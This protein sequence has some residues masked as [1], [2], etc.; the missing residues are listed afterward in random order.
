MRAPAA[1][2]GAFIHE[3][4]TCTYIYFEEMDL[5][6]DVTTERLFFV[7]LIPSFFFFFLGGGGWCVYCM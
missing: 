3:K 7:C 4:G 6:F 1:V 5:C 2:C